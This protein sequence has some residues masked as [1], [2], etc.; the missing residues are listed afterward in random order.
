MENEKK[1]DIDAFVI[2]IRRIHSFF[3]YESYW[4]KLLCCYLIILISAIPFYFGYQIYPVDNEYNQYDMN[5]ECLSITQIGYYQDRNFFNLSYSLNTKDLTTRDI[6]FSLFRIIV[7]GQFYKEELRRA[8]SDGLFQYQN[9]LYSISFELFQEGKTNLTIKCLDRELFI[10][11]I[12]LNG[13]QTSKFTVFHNDDSISNICLSNR[14]KIIF[15]RNNVKNFSPKIKIALRPF[16]F[17]NS[18]IESYVSDSNSKYQLPSHPVIEII[19]KTTYELL[20]SILPFAFYLSKNNDNNRFFKSFL[21]NSNSKELND[22]FEFIQAIVK[23]PLVRPSGSFTNYCYLGNNVRLFN[24]SFLH[25]LQS[26]QIED[27]SKRLFGK[28]K[29]DDEI[30]SIYDSFRQFVLSK[31]GSDDNKLSQKPKIIFTL[32][33]YDDFS[34]IDDLKQFFSSNE[35][36][37]II[38]L[39]DLSLQQKIL[40]I[41]NS[42]IMISLDDGDEVSNAMW[43]PINSTLI[44]LREK[45]KKLSPAIKFIQ[46]RKI[47]VVPADYYANFDFEN[48]Y[49]QKIEIP[50]K[51]IEMILKDL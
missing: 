31:Y 10:K 7:N 19:Q 14:E 41:S 47:N 33:S 45:N 35:N 30:E 12:E 3:R 25:K 16:T 17:K 36:F 32:N 48:D 46:N 40:E 4:F 39:S 50:L 42:S 15:I 37:K 22:L 29:I 1:H 51:T 6:S 5:P 8:N 20:S 26:K 43:M 23:E 24:Y 44:L 9:D 18:T 13:I 11:D 49:A 2:I 21:V 38:D 27:Q 34:N 28:D